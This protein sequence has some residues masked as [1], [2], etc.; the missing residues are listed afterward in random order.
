MGDFLRRLRT[1]PREA[2]RLSGSLGRLTNLERRVDRLEHALFRNVARFVACEQIEGDY[3]EFG[4]YR[5]ATFAANY[6]I[7]CEIFEARIR[8]DNGGEDLEENANHRQAIWDSMRFF[9]FDSFE[10]LPELTVEDAESTDFTAGQYACSVD[11]FMQNMKRR[12]VPTE[13]VIP[14][15]GW[16]ENSCNTQTLGEHGIHK[17]AVVFIDCDI[18]SATKTVLEFV[19]PLLQDGSVLIFDDWF[20]YRG[21][22]GRGE[23]RAFYEWSS[24]KEI[25]D[26]FHFTE[27]HK[28][29]WKRNSFIVNSLDLQE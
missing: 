7:F 12:S 17:A 28:D 14:V 21:H 15:K 25:A 3:M 26:R 10:G 8:Q 9:A 22:P 18:Y 29:S 16:F 1:L 11:Q 23:Q 4:V 19:G 6:H 13:R 27:Y 24:S 5:G 20:S 2:Y